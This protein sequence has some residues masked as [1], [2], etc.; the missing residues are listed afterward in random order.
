MFE[1]TLPSLSAGVLPLAA[2][3]FL[4]GTT[5]AQVLDV[6]VTGE[7]EFNLVSTGPIAQAPV[8]GAASITFQVDASDF[9]DSPNFPTRGYAIQPGTFA[10][11]LGPGSV[12]LA[13]PFPP[14]QTAYFVIRNDDPAVDGFFIATSVD[15]PIGVP[16]NLQGGFGAFGLDFSVTYTGDT[17]DSL[18]VSDAVGDYDFTG[19]T[20]FGFNISDG[21]FEP[22]GMVFESLSIV[23]PN[24]PACGLASV[25]VYTSVTG[26]PANFLLDI[27]GDP[28]V[29]GT[30]TAVVPVTPGPA[31]FVAF[32]TAAADIPLFDSALLIDPSQQFLQLPIQ[33]AF[34]PLASV[35]I[36]ANPNLAGLELFAQAGGLDVTLPSQVALSNGASFSICP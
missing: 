26:V 21:P 7:I 27:A 14:G 36:P 20:V 4:T 30:F 17:L 5:Q 16:L 12:P 35:A 28:S 24:P 11:D 1:A 29:G 34:P 2:F 3:A 13:N 8:G 32:S 6:T 25:E 15:F 19:L 10:L 22:V 23:D 18:D 9:V 33:P 31:T